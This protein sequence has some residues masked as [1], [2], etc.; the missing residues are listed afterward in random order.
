MTISMQVKCI[1]H[2]FSCAS[3]LSLN[4]SCRL[5]QK[6]QSTSKQTEDT[7]D[8]RSAKAMHCLFYH[9]KQ[10]ALTGLDNTCRFRIPGWSR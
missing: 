1:R 10:D 5:R 4:R 9:C 8:W 3:F 7:E 6:M 2:K